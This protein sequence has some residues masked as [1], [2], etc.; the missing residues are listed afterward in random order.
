MAWC[1]GGCPP[2]PG[3]AV[4]VLPWQWPP[5]TTPATGPQSNGAM[6]RRAE[7]AL[8]TV[9]AIGCAAVHPTALF[10]ASGQA[11]D[12]IAGAVRQVKAGASGR[13]SRAA[14]LPTLF[15]FVW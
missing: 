12:L 6:I 9:S 3:A 5:P 7:A 1:G 15:Q 8:K 13:N 14:A 2:W 10:N 4:A 11:C